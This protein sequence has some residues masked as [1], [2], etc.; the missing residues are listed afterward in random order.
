MTTPEPQGGGAAPPAEPAA[1]QGGDGQ[2][3]DEQVAQGFFDEF[4]E[5]T[6]RSINELKQ[7]VAHLA[8]VRTP[9]GS[10]SAGPTPNE[11]GA[12]ASSGAAQGQSQQAAAPASNTGQP[13]GGAPATQPATETGPKPGNWYY[14]RIFGGG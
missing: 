2:Q 3:S 14:K 11:P 12:A 6:R 13:G 9:G 10:S 8:N 1:P 5:E 7:A 4:V